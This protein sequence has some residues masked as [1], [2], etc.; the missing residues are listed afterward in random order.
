VTARYV[1]RGLLGVVLAAA[2]VV[3]ASAT[4]YHLVRT[5]SCASGGPYVSARP[6]PTGTG[7]RIL[8]LIGSI[9]VLGPLSVFVF[10]SRAKGISGVPPVAGLVGLLWS[11]GWI[12]MGTAAWVA[13]HGPA[14][15]VD[16]GEGSAGVAITFWAIGGISLLFVVVGLLGAGA[17]ARSRA[18]AGPPR[19]PSAAPPPPPRAPALVA[20][21]APVSDVARRLEQLDE[22]RALGAVTEAEYAAKR[23][24][25]LGGI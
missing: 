20:P 19:A 16:G 6:C 2:A 10:A 4:I 15:P 25:I 22:L 14:A 23:R 9:F 18:A 8:A 11:V 1:L 12:A 5:G 21:A 13:G 3:V 17:A 24:E 7:L